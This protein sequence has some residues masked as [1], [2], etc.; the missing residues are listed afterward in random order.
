MKVIWSK[1]RLLPG[2]GGKSAENFKKTQLTAPSNVI[3]ILKERN[4]LH[5]L[6]LLV[7]H[8][9]WSHRIFN[10]HSSATLNIQHQI[11]PIPLKPRDFNLNATYSIPCLTASHKL[12]RVLKIYRRTYENQ[13][14]YLAR[15]NF[16]IE[17]SEHSLDVTIFL[18]NFNSC[19]YNK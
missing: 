5:L 9:S 2:C 14:L 3:R 6:S 15:Y 13:D 16:Y 17:S 1:M 4:Q 11:M 12:P 7:Q 8:S 19:F 18:L 10:P